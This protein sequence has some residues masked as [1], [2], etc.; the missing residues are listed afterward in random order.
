MSEWDDYESGPF[1][2]HWGDPS[3]CHAVC[4][5][6]GHAC[7]RHG[8][9]DDTGCEVVLQ[10]RDYGQTADYCTCEAWVEPD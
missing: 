4:A 8:R 1:C 6:C 7:S 3:D 9:G 10:Y 2:R 5:A